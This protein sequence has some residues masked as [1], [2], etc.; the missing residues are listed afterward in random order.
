MALGDTSSMCFSRAWATRRISGWG[1]PH[2]FLVFRFF[3]GSGLQGASDGKCNDLMEYFFPFLSLSL[4]FYHG[5]PL[6]KVKMK[7]K[8]SSYPGNHWLMMMKVLKMLVVIVVNYASL[9]VELGYLTGPLHS[10]AR[11]VMGSSLTFSR[12][13]K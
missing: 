13:Q 5:I 2:F 4:S 11:K 1:L 9:I 12:F 8:C 6:S 10:S 7:R 3:V